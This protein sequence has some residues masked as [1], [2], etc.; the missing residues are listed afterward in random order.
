MKSEGEGGLCVRSRSEGSSGARRGKEAG[1]QAGNETQ[2]AEQ[3]LGCGRERPDCTQS[4]GGC[5]VQ[6]VK[7]R[8]LWARLRTKCRGKAQ[9]EWRRR[10]DRAGKKRQGRGYLQGRRAEG[11]AWSTSLTI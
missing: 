3:R 1:E 4:P 11:E 9:P 7:G 5:V 10:K 8:E 6:K 2:R